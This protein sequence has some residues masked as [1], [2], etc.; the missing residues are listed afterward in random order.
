LSEANPLSILTID[1]AGRILSWNKGAEIMFGW[2]E[3][4]AVGRICPTVPESGLED[5]GQM[6]AR[7]LRGESFAGYVRHRQKKDNSLVEA[8]IACAPLISGTGATVGIVAILEDITERKRAEEKIR[9]SQVLFQSTFEQAAVGIAHT[10]PEG[11]FIRINRRFCDI[12]GYTE[13]EMLDLT[14]QDIT[15]PE[16]LEADMEHVPK[17]LANEIKTYSTEKRYYRK[18]GTIVWVNLTASLVR[19]S[20]GNPWYFIGIIEDIT[21]RKEVEEQLQHTPWNLAEIAYQ[22]HERMDGSG[23]PRHLKGEDI[24]IEARILAVADT[25]EAMSSHRPY[26]PGLGIDAALKEIEKNKGIL[27][28]A[29]AVD[30]CL[31]L[32]REKRYELPQG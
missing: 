22:H 18:N 5:F 27:Y 32:F 7:G 30:A 6:V 2:T 15:Y 3:Q 26:R 13:D 12:A 17:L 24:L 11:Q 20:S 21:R 28:D 31:G 19:R 8:N 16:D 4:E 25:V 1:P 23:Y 14:F 10:T 29:D 9:E